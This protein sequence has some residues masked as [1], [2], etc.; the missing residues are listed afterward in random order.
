MLLLRDAQVSGTQ[1]LSLTIVAVAF[2]LHEA[3]AD[4]DHRLDAPGARSER[5]THAPNVD[6][7]RARVAVMIWSPNMIEQ[8]LASG[9]AARARDQH[10]E[11]GEF[12][13]FEF[14]CDAFARDAHARKVD[15]QAPVCVILIRLIKTTQ[16]GANPRCVF[17]G[18]VSNIFGAIV[19]K[20]FDSVSKDFVFSVSRFLRFPKRLLTLP[21]T[22][23]T[24]AK[25]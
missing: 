18:S 9:D 8:M 19:S 24:P 1:R 20:D 23:L 4:A 3:I 25:S 22:L 7:E 11:E 5:L 2:A 15:G 10:R 6:V 14:H 17:R 12:L 13:T 21:K 16:N